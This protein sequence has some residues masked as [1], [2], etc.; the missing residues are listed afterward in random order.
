MCAFFS[1][2]LH[3]YVKPR[4]I[5]RA[6]VGRHIISNLRYA[7]DTVIVAESKDNLQQLLDIV[8][9]ESKK[10]R[11]EPKALFSDKMI[12]PFGILK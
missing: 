7:D 10:K 3:S 8:E 5:P 11:L 4:R 12:H 1:L 2:Q 6:E 9:E